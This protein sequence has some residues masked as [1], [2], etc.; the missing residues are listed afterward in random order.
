VTRTT[1]IE[2]AAALFGLVGAALLATRNELAPWGWLA[3]LASNAGWIA[4]GCI[5]RLWFLVLH[6]VGF[7]ATSLLG[8]HNWILT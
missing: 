2:A 1:A 7:T 5:R 4:F 3:F 8:V 6:Q